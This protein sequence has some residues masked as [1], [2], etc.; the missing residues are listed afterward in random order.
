MVSLNFKISNHL[1]II[2]IILL[3]IKKKWDKITFHSGFIKYITNT[4]WLFVGQILKMILAF[5][6]SAAIARHMGPE[7]FGLYNYVIAAIS[8]IIP[9]ANLGIQNVAKR[10]MISHPENKNAILGTCFTL[11]TISGTLLYCILLIYVLFISNNPT[12][13]VALYIYLGSGL[14]LIGFD[15]IDSWFQAQTRAK[16]SVKASLAVI[17]LSTALKFIA[18][19]QD[20]GIITFAAITCVELLVLTGI[21]IWIYLQEYGSIFHWNFNSKIAQ[22]LIKECWPIF[23]TGIAVTI[24][25]RIDQVMLGNMLDNSALGIYSAATKISGMWY[26]IPMLLC[27]S[28]YPAIVNARKADHKLY[29]YRLTKLG[30]FLAMISYLIIIFTCLFS[31]QIIKTIYGDA[32]SE[33]SNILVIHTLTIAPIFIG[34]V[35]IQYINTEKKHNFM[36][37]VSCIGAFTNFIFNVLLIPKFGAIGAAYA[38][39]ISKGPLFYILLA[40]IPSMREAFMVFTRSMLLGLSLAKISN[41][42]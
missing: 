11:N 17:L 29:L 38:N 25:V 24:D 40:T 32:Y 42:N 14:A 39:L 12:G 19:Y 33:S 1:K 23:L 16:L 37:L 34:A 9:F 6:A 22:S 35:I 4:G 7:E 26:F 15:H 41:K 28:L 10:D 13:G 27:S 31:D 20:R 36:L 18:I 8:L 2:N 21:R 5:V 3:K 30:G